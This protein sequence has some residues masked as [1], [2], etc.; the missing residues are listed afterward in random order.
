MG[1]IPLFSA[2]PTSSAIPE[3]TSQVVPPVLYRWSNVDSIGINS[4][5]HLV[6]GLFASDLQIR[7]PAEY[8]KED[9]KNLVL[10]HVRI[11]K[12]PTPFISTFIT[13][14][15]P[16]HRAFQRGQGAIV[17]IIDP[18][19]LRT[20]LFSAKALVFKL[21]LRNGWYCGIGEYLIWGRVPSQAIVASFKVSDLEKIAA[22]D[23]EIANILQVD[24]IQSHG[25]CGDKLR[26]ALSTGPGK[27]DSLSGFIVGRL[28]RR[29]GIPQ[30]HSEAVAY[31]ITRSWGFG[32]DGR[33]G[34][35][36]QF[37]EGL[38]DAY[39]APSEHSPLV[40]SQS[41]GHVPEEASDVDDEDYVL[42]DH[43]E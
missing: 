9:F 16:I 26:K 37:S 6:A 23:P 1:A 4:R 13:P 30:S 29:L 33:D 17:T 10:H 12:V 14:L 19:K 38:S 40:S 21:G 42:V 3:F 2:S 18:S 7:S 27:L 41:N 22:E 20:P 31:N 35:W 36:D 25:S 34:T 8:S 43:E 39:T 15:S 11:D 5:Q 28:L 32:R 24:K